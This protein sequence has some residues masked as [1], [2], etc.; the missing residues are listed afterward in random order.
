THNVPSLVDSND[1]LFAFTGKLRHFDPTGFDEIHRVG[2]I[3]DRKNH[4]V[5]FETRCRSESIQFAQVSADQLR[6]NL[7]VAV[8]FKH[9][10]LSPQ[11]CSPGPSGRSDRALAQTRYSS[12]AGDA[13]RPPCCHSPQKNSMALSGA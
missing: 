8:T 4:F 3:A 13:E 12:R 11:R 10:S 9:L 5:R 7:A 1:L 6:K 2:R